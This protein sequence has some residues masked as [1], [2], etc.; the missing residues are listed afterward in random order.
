MDTRL[1][2]AVENAVAS[3]LE[4]AGVA[5]AAP[6]MVALSGG[7]D[8]VALLYAMWRLRGAAVRSGP[9]FAAHLNHRM[10]PSEADR[11][12]AFVRSLCDRLGIELAVERARGLDAGGNIE[13]RARR[14]RSDFLTRVAASF[15]VNYIALAHNRDDQA[16]TVL[17]RLM[18]G[19][20]VAG[21]AAIALAGPGGIVRPLLDVSR[22]RILKYLDALGAAY[23][24]DSTNSDRRF[25]RNRIRH[26]LIPY[27]E[28]DYAQGIG[29]RLAAIASEMRALDRFLQSTADAELHRRLDRSG[30]MAT[31]GFGAL[32]Q[33]L[34]SAMV[35]QWLR[36]ALGDLRRVNRYQIEQI[37]RLFTEGQAGSSIALPG[38][39][40]VR[41][42]YGFAMVETAVIPDAPAYAHTLA[43][44]GATEAL[45]AGLRFIVRFVSK[46]VLL[47]ACKGGNAACSR[48][49]A[50]F[51]ATAIHRGLSVRNFNEG[52]R[53]AP[54]GMT[55]TRKVQDVFVDRK[56]SRARRATWPMVVADG[57]IVWIPGLIRSRF[58]LVNPASREVLEIE[59]RP[60]RSA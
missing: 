21:L 6:V 15:G 3:S 50:W 45:S 8:S 55:G 51:D 38:G 29:R 4:R 31:R 16:E 32:P 41:L 14:I 36:I 25:L 11:D 19:S 54:L 56:T 23:V 52:D 33:A 34:A 24:T 40:R 39:R 53:I 42:D 10:R 35:R 49:R 13:E 7:P 47:G 5:P 57:Q 30:R 60:L 12:E 18:R 46:D 44:P 28:R 20:G 37:V 27:L 58:G 43:I 2:T 59:A 1:T 26:E 9:L 22:D 17:M 48:N